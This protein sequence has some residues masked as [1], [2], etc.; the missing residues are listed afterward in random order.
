MRVVKREMMRKKV[1]ET[2]S[3]SQ[4]ATAKRIAKSFENRA[5]T[6]QT[7][8]DKKERRTEK[9]QERLSFKHRESDENRNTILHNRSDRYAKANGAQETIQRKLLT[10][11][12]LLDAHCEKVYEGFL[13]IDHQ[14]AADLH[15]GEARMAAESSRA[16]LARLTRLKQV[17]DRAA[18]SK[19]KFDARLQAKQQSEK[20]FLE[21]NRAKEEL[22]NKGREKREEQIRRLIQQ[23]WDVMHVRMAKKTERIQR[24]IEKAHALYEKKMDA[25]LEDMTTKHDKVRVKPVKGPSQVPPNK[26]DHLVRMNKRRINCGKDF[27]TEMRVARWKRQQGRRDRRQFKIA[28]NIK[29]RQKMLIDQSAE[30]ARMKRLCERLRATADEERFGNIVK[31]LGLS[32]IVTIS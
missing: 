9:Q 28:N 19:R 17:Q 29:T 27:V 30:R 25:Q 11:S 6:I 23:R 7:R 1:L 2:Y 18:E 14:R 20:D 21:V 12:E 22:A 31:L 13:R 10:E 16:D 24:S 8:Q 32:K 3:K 26:Y 5:I 4:E 15:A